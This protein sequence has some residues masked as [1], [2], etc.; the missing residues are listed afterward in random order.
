MEQYI[1]WSPFKDVYLEDSYVLKI[2]ESEKMVEFHIEAVLLENHEY[3][4]APSNGEQY[5]FKEGIIRFNQFSEV[6]WLHSADVKSFDASGESDLGNIDFLTK[7]GNIYHLAGD[8][9]EVKISAKSISFKLT[10]G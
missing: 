4:E 8:W 1:D 10:L 3:Y 6:N 9:G 2:I 7:T 5:F